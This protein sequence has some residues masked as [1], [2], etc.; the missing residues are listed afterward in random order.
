VTPG[1]QKAGLHPRRS[2]RPQ[3]RRLLGSFRGIL[4]RSDRHARDDLVRMST[5]WIGGIRL[6]EN[7]VG[8]R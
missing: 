3:R 4:L 8:E 2:R 7:S 5:L 6:G 1:Q